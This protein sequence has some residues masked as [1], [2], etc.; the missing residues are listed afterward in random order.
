MNYVGKL[1]WALMSYGVYVL[2]HLY[3]R[4]SEN[5]LPCEFHKHWRFLYNAILLFV[6][7]VRKTLF[8]LL[9]GYMMNGGTVPVSSSADHSLLR[10]FRVLFLIL[11]VVH[12]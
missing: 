5:V 1:L 2:V 8:Y 7:V 12:W 9:H 6:I 11:A 10:Q 3:L 4:L